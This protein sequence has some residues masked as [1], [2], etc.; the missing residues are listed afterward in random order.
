L[1]YSHHCVLYTATTVFY[2]QP[3]LCF[4]GLRT[5]CVFI[6]IIP[7]CY[8]NVMINTVRH[9][10]LYIHIYMY[11]AHYVIYFTVVP[12]YYMFRLSPR[13]PTE[14]CNRQ[15]SWSR[16]AVITSGFQVSNSVKK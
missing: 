15:P 9:T 16:R 11:I 5:P 12:I 4:K 13:L 10:T 2:I 3:P 6:W 8:F 14:Q 1:I 7:V